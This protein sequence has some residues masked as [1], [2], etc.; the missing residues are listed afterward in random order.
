M[1]TQEN[2]QDLYK[3]KEYLYK[4]ICVKETYKMLMS[5]TKEDLNKLRYVLY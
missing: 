4:R 5:T 2:M 1:Q 3:M